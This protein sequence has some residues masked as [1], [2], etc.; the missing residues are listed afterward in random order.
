MDA[1]RRL[2]LGRLISL[3]GG[4]AAYI[5]LIAAIYGHTGSAAWVSAAL[6]AGVTGSVVGAPGAGWVGDRFDR[7]R[8]MI[9]ADLGAAA[10]STALALAHEPAALV[11]LFGVGAIVTSPFEPASAAALPTRVGEESLARANALVASTASAGY[12]LGPFAGRVL[13]V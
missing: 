9:A 13:L 4:S 7:R 5:A 11:A 3:T 6:F 10:I 1:A 2:A 12:L 8:V